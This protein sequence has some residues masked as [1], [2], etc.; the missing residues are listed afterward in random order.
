M[1][2]MQPVIDAI[3]GLA[4]VDEVQGETGDH[5][6]GPIYAFVPEGKRLQD[7]GPLFE[8]L[9]PAPRWIAANASALSVPSFVDYMNRFKTPDSAIFASDDPAKPSLLGVVDFHG[10]GST[11]SPRFGRHSVSYGFPVSDQINAW[12]AVSG[13][14]LD[15]ETMASFLAER[16]HDIANP[17]LDWMMVEPDTIKLLMHLL[18]IADDAG[19]VDDAAA[20]HEPAAE[21][22]DRYVPRSAIYKLRKIRFG[23]AQRLL[24]LARTVE[25]SVNS[26]AV[27]GYSPKTGERTVQFTEEHETSS[28]GMKV[29]VPDAFLLRVPV[30][31]GETTMLIPVRLQYR[32]QGGSL[33]WFMT[34]VEWKR[35][36]RFAVNAE[37]QRV[38]TLTA[39]PVFFGRPK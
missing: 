17:P 4:V 31:E 9:R 16:Q 13:K 6:K 12:S 28:R 27:E 19:D 18:N 29:V 37:A 32:K 2:D 1:T 24:Q 39:L 35:V 26:K 23:S 15:H 22:D 3:K 7:L 34:L 33:R 25:V 14:V 36:I 10:Q 20:D 11:A 21:D 38:H 30:W 5:D 8:A